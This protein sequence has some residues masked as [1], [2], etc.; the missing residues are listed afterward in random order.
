MSARGR[1]PL[2][3]AGALAPAVVIVVFGIGACDRRATGEVGSAEPRPVFVETAPVTTGDV[4]VAI[5][6]VGTL[7]PHHRV[8]VRAR[9]EG[10]VAN[11]EVSE[12]EAV[13]LG[14]PLLELDTTKLAAEVRLREASLAAAR[15]RATNARSSFARARDLLKGGF[16]PQQQFDDAKAAA[17][18]SAAEVEEADAALAVALELL[19][20]ASVRAPL[21]GV[22]GEAN[23][24]PG[25]YVRNGDP[26]VTIVDADPIEVAFSLPE[27][28]LSKLA[29]GRP[30]SVRVP[31]YPGAVFEGVLTYIDPEVQP[32]THA[33]RLK[34]RIP[35]ANGRLRPGQFASVR[36]I[37]EFHRASTLVPE[38][39]IVPEGAATWVF[40]VENGRASRR[41]VDLGIRRG[42]LV[43]VTSGLGGGETVVV[44]GQFRLHDGG[45]VQVAPA[46]AAE[47]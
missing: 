42:G 7:H 47:G 22:A 1:T 19:R 16:I 23:V 36:A 21:A 9:V 26:L 38:E 34:A 12:G 10:V 44:N 15:A 25:D 3:V 27:E 39:A 4:E 14:D 13:A 40:V 18:A 43:E 35:N 31:S 11:V 32:D 41:R 45:A 8:V 33:V 30:V 17:E 2:L 29:L 20:E 37:L 5:E 28:H 6:A 24:D 46:R